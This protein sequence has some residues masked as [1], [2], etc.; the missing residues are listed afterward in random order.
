[1]KGSLIMI[2]A[3]KLHEYYE[4]C[5]KCVGI[6]KHNNKL[7]YAISGEEGKKA[8]AVAKEI[9]TMI[10]KKDTVRCL[11]DKTFTVLKLRDYRFP[12]YTYRV[13]YIYDCLYA[14]G[15]AVFIFPEYLGSRIK[16]E[17]FILDYRE[18]YNIANFSCVERKIIG[19]VGK[20]SIDITVGCR[21][22]YKCLPVI[23]VVTY[24]D[25]IFHEVHS[26]RSSRNINTFTYIK[27]I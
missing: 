22:C 14:G 21:P 4:E 1:M 27:V 19:T 8:N 16:F 25:Q 12:Q 23:K 18:W 26:F 11:I 10:G 13:D 15:K 17:K 5:N 6:A 20:Q 3:V 9:E 7:Y 24:Y 2:S